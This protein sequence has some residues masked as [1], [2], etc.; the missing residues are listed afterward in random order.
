MVRHKYSR[1][2]KEQL[3]QVVMETPEFQRIVARMGMTDGAVRVWARSVVKGYAMY[4]L[5]L[6][7]THPSQLQIDGVPVERMLAE[8]Q[9]RRKQ[10]LSPFH[11]VASRY[12]EAPGC[13]LMKDRAGEVIYV[14]KAKNLR[15]RLS[16]YFQRSIDWKK[17][18]LLVGEISDIEIIIVNN[19]PESLFLEN[20]L[21][22]LY[23]PKYN[24]SLMREDSGY[25]YIVLTQER[26]PRL[27]FYRKGRVNRDL[28]GSIADL[29]EKR[30]GPFL[31]AELLLQIASENFQLRTC[32]TLE[33]R[34][35]LSYHLKRCSGICE[36][37]VTDEEYEQA[38]QKVITFFSYRPEER[39]QEMRRQMV[40]YAEGL[41]FERAQKIKEQIR[42]LENTL[43][44]QIVDRDVEVDQD[45]IYFGVDKVLVTE[46]MSGMVRNM[47]MYDLDRCEGDEMACEQWLVAR[48]GTASPDELIVNHLAEPARVEKVL[49]LTNGRK[50]KITVP[51]KGVKADLVKLCE[52][53]YRYRVEGM[54][55]CAAE[56]NRG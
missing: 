19:E 13:Y 54:S 55:A 5:V 1:E 2:E 45:V 44:K 43:E 35:C 31:N 16:S 29:K 30:F 47:Q 33:K 24:R 32:K 46:I 40:E 37:L 48:Y 18:E 36:H 27:A 53:N 14:G 8:F 28:G 11:F 52:R 42:L 20:N 26:Y 3:L 49:T 50:V 41:E 15:N 25:A 21:I 9:Q 4:N 17:T 6:D 51:K 23:Q 56:E 12:P 38:V 34:V 10:S 39:I 22:K 7:E